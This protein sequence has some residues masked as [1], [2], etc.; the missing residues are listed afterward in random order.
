MAD[1]T[2]DQVRV[3][4][5]VVDAGSFGRAAKRL[6]RAQS[7]VSYAVANLERVLELDLFD[8]RGNQARL[9]E[10]ARTLLPSARA[11]LD[12]A[13]RLALEA[14][15][16]GAGIEVELR[17]AVDGLMPLDLVGRALEQVRAEYPASTLSVRS[18]AL[19]AVPELLLQR[20]VDVGVSPHF[21]QHTKV[22]EAA[23]IATVDM[24]CVAA[25]G[26]APDTHPQI[27]IRDRT[28]LTDNVSFAIVSGSQYHVADAHTKLDMLLLGMGWGMFPR[29]LITD[30]LATARLVILE[31]NSVPRPVS[32]VH[33]VGWLRDGRLGRVGERFVQVLTELSEG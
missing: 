3:F 33:A 12:R 17:I 15:S 7:A 8:R 11:L 23:P 27:V 32:V 18:E 28:R 10:E 9:T 31:G 21:Q 5:T 2:L 29:E 25:P 14:E 19:G 30:P 20:Q 24:I 6:N 16:L 26:V 1:F 4:V 13:H 22:I